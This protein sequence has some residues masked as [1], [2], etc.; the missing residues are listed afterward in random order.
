[1][2]DLIIAG[3]SKAKSA[4]ELT[5]IA[6][7]PGQS[8]HNCT[9]GLFKL[10]PPTLTTI[11]SS[12]KYL[13]K[14]VQKN[15]CPKKNQKLVEGPIIIPAPKKA[16]ENVRANPVKSNQSNAILNPVNESPQ[17]S[18]NRDIYRFTYRSLIYGTKYA[19]TI[20]T[21]ANIELHNNHLNCFA[22]VAVSPSK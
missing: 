4:N 18:T 1:M 2:T 9:D 6:V 20:Q 13:P 22:P 14:I 10:R 5:I 8:I 16:K 19:N 3:T 17:V 7:I 15:T 12:Y 11:P 21:N